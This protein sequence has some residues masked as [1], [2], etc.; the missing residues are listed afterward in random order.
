MGVSSS[1][2]RTSAVMSLGASAF[3]LA[4][5]SN[6]VEATAGSPASSSQAS[7]NERTASKSSTAVP[8]KTLPADFPTDIHVAAGEI[9]T[10]AGSNGSWQVVVASPSTPAQFEA[11]KKKLI[12]AGFTENFYNDDNN[13]YTGEYTNGTYTVQLVVGAPDFNGTAYIVTKNS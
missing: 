12:D 8:A 9:V 5:C 6:P 10:A 3:L 2:L 4:A 7:E 13:V 1:V 11:A